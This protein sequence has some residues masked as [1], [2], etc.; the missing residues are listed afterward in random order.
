MHKKNL[1]LRSLYDFA[2]SI[3]FINFL[4]YF[5]QRIVIDGGLSD[6][7]YN[8][9]FAIT[10][11]L[12]FLSAPMLAAYTDKHGGRKFFLNISTT[13]TFVSYGLAALLATTGGASIFIIALLFLIG[14][15][16]YQLSFVFYNP[17]LGEIADVTHRA[18]ASGIG[19][20]ANALGQ[21][22]G[23]LITLPLAD[24]RTAP[25]LPAVGIFFVLAL[26]MMIF[27]QENK[28][29]DRALSFSTM[30]TETAMFRKKIVLFFT[31]SV[32]TPVL[33]AFF[34]FNDALITVS[35][36]YSIYMERVF[37]IADTTK[38]LLLLSILAM[39]AIGGVIAGWLG[40]KIGLLKTLK[41][42][43]LLRVVALPTIAL[44]SNFIVFAMITA[45]VG[46]L[47]G[48]VFSTTRAYVSTL[49]AE[50]E[51]GY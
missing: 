4:L 18:R 47:I 25:L 23:L 8:A 36:N 11:V 50:E 5:A 51:M 31:L 35:N 2:N 14:Q 41:L 26:P 12:L 40:D 34:F 44:T 30:R 15:Y 9:I 49:L 28:K 43:L 38:S 21:A 42:I 1:F 16:F 32:A 10:T 19:Q 45:L 24:S 48:S 22:A 33:L 27:F 39:S 6:F 13:G 37:S 3:V 7:R 46:L 17:M 29:R 20:F